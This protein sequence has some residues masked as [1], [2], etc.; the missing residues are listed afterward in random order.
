MKIVTLG[1]VSSLALG[2]A[3]PAFAQSV[4]AVAATDLNIRSGPGPVYDVVGVITGGD[5]VPVSRCM[6]A[7]SWCEVSYNGVTGWS[8][9]DYLAIGVD[10]TAVALAT[11]PS[12]VTVETVTVENV[13]ETQSDRNA[14]AAAGA[15]IGALAAY[16]LGGPIA[17][18]AAGGILG[19]AGGTALVEPTEETV[20]YITQ[21]PV[22]TVY[23]EGEVVVGAG[24][25]STVTTYEVPQEGLRYLSVN[26]QTVLVDAET[27]AIVRVVR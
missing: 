24:I 17:G 8:S 4:E 9:S 25:P 6:D 20:T 23:L 2:A 5:A 26:G 3:A 11:R 15:T 10:E 7:A 12:S 14:G 27:N 18:I 16:A 21:N 19:A 22:E 13:T 1:L